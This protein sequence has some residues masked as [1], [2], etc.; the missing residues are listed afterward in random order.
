MYRRIWLIYAP[1]NGGGLFFRFAVDAVVNNAYQMYHQPHLNPGECK[2]DALGLS[3]A[4]LDAYYRLF[5]KHFPSTTLFTGSYSL[6]HP[7]NNL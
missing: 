7:A 5:R 1:R 6:H 3:R 4:I 2:L